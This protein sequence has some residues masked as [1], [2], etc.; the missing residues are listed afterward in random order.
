MK[1]TIDRIE[2]EL[3]ICEDE[4]GDRI[5]LNAGEIPRDAKEGDILENLLGK[6]QI[7]REA[8]LCR[9]QEMREKLKRLIE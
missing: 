6:W 2:E 3:V 7:D 1:Y 8:T 5:K 9:R 4:R